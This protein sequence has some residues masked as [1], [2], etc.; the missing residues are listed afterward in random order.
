MQT[1]ILYIYTPKL[2]QNNSQ[3]IIV[4][5][6]P[7]SHIKILSFDVPILELDQSSVLHLQSH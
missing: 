1:Y 4:D 6:N 5:R 2:V 3:N 7:K